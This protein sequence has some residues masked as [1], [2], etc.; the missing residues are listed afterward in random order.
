MREDSN[1][2]PTGSE[3]Q[4]ERDPPSDLGWEGGAMP[5]LKTGSAFGLVLLFALML[6]AAT[7]GGDE[8]GGSIT[9][10]GQKANDHGSQDAS[11]ESELDLE[12]DDFYFEPT[13][14][15]GSPGETLTLDL[16]NEG[17]AEHNF[18]LTD[19]GIDEDVE[20]GEKAEVSVTFPDS[21]TLVFFCKY[22]QDMGMRGALTVS[23]A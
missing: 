18:S 13:V 4:R 17:D 2:R 21:G 1:P 14:L 23:S 20:A 7:C 6:V 5:R 12:L 8:E 19:Q 10:S 16:E 3:R 11:R 9:V 22:H 15:T